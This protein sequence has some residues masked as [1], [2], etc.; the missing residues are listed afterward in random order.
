MTYGVSIATPVYHDGIV[1]VAG[2]WEGA[3]AIKLGDSAAQA[4]ILWEENRYLR[5]LMSQPLVQDG[6]G[7]LLD[8]QHGLVCFELSTG[9]MKWTDQNRLTP[10]GRN[11]QVNLVWLQRAKIAGNQR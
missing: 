10:R 4:K 11:P 3:K 7:Y 1:V 5:G 2:Y 9:K 8:K 6:Y